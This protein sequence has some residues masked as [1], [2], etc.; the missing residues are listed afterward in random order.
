MP[1]STTPETCF[2]YLLRHGATDNN[3]AKPPRLQGKTVDGP[4]SAEGRRQ[5]ELAAQGLQHQQLDAVFCSPLRRAQE[6]AEIVARPHR[7]DVQVV[8]QISEVDVGAW[9]GRTWEEIERSEPELYRQFMDDPARHG[10]RDG[11]SLTDVRDRVVPVLDQLL[12]DNQGKRIAVIAHN[13]VNRVYLA[14][15]AKLPLAQARSLAQENCGIN[16]L[17]FRAGE[18]KLIS[19]NSVLHLW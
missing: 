13:V 3:L 9:E 12:R 1:P 15:A 5:A 6:T 11:E 17:R 8:P 7:L 16:V 14:T 18:I 10:Y 2:V 4:L 19:M